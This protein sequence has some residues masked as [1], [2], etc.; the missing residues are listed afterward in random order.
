MKLSPQKI[1]MIL[2][3][4]GIVWIFNSYIFL[5]SPKTQDS[6]NFMANGDFGNKLSDL[7]LSLFSLFPPILIII[8]SIISFQKH[9]PS[10]NFGMLIL[11]IFSIGWFLYLGSFAVE[12]YTSSTGSFSD[13]TPVYSPLYFPIILWPIISLIGS[14]ILLRQKK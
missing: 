10:I 3:L 5:N 1:S 8:M 2:S 7:S 13:L 11:S 12:G 6:T 4:V 9:I 14:I